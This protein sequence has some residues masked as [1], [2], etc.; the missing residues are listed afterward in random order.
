MNMFGEFQLQITPGSAETVTPIFVKIPK[1]GGFRKMTNCSLSQNFSRR[2][3]YLVKSTFLED[4][5]SEQRRYE[6]KNSLGGSL[7]KMAK[8]DQ[9]GHFLTFDPHFLQNHSP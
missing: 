9:N 1:N 3:V 8:N 5:N 2:N 4:A 7:S 6:S